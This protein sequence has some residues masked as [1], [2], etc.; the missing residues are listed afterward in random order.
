MTKG[1]GIDLVDVA[2]IA[3][4][5]E[6]HEARMKARLFTPAEQA[7][8]D[9]RLTPTLHYAARFAAK[10]AFSKAIGTGFTLGLKWTEIEVVNLETGEPTLRVTGRAA[11]AMRER[12]ATRAFVS[13]THSTTAAAAVV[14]LEVD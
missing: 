11:E 13:L 12:G 4:A 6:R 7:Y 14:L 2:R 5:F 8:C 3:Q 1:I 9:A 10:E